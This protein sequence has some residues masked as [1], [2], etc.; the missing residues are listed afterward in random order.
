VRVGRLS[1]FPEGVGV[2][3]EIGARRIVVYRQREYLFALKNLCPHQGEP[4]HRLPPQNGAAVCIG[5]G[6]AFDLRTG[7]CV[8]GD[9]GSRVAVYPVQVRNGEVFIGRRPRD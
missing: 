6:W 7:R 4:L 1:D 5:H 9:L 8:R 3:V 2:P